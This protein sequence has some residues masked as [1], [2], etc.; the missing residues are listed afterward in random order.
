MQSPRPNMGSPFRSVGPNAPYSHI[1]TSQEQIPKCVKGQGTAQALQ[2]L[3]DA[4]KVWVETKYDGERAQIHVRLE[5]DGLP[6]IKIFSKSG[7]DSTLDRAGIHTYDLRAIMVCRRLLIHFVGSFAMP[8]GSE[9]GRVCSQ[10]HT[11][12]SLLEELLP[13]SP[14]TSSSRQKWSRFQTF[15]IESTVR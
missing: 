12:L 10:G 9:D 2:V 4:D 11:A 5:E 6:R 13:H 8:L 14:T 15:S 1:L 7:R 3:K